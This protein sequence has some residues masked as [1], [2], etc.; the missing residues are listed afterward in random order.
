MIPGQRARARSLA[1]FP[2]PATLFLPFLLFLPLYH[3]LTS[4]YLYAALLLTTVF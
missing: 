3:R 4:V 2:M 1:I